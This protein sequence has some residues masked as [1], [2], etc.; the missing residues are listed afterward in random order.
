MPIISMFFGLIIR[1]YFEDHNPPHMHVE[2]Q[3]YKAIFDLDGNIV[4]GKMP[5]T[6]CRLVAAWCE[7]HREE[8]LA[9]WELCKDG[10]KPYSIKPLE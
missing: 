2:Y 5:K 8:L 7:I 6:Q 3:G 1:M 4:S 9:N 10:E